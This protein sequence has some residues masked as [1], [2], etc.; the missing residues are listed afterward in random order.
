[1]QNPACCEA[2]GPRCTE[3]AEE[4]SGPR[5]AELT[6]RRRGRRPCCR[7]MALGGATGG[8][9]QRGGRLYQLPRWRKRM[10]RRT[11]GRWLAPGAARHPNA[12]QWQVGQAGGGPAACAAAAA[13]VTLNAPLPCSLSPWAKPHPAPRLSRARSRQPTRARE[14]RRA[15]LL[16]W[17]LIQ[18]KSDS[19]TDL[20]RLPKKTHDRGA[21]RGCL[22]GARRLPGSSLDFG[23]ERSA[24]YRTGC[25]G[26]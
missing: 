13:A 23:L 24:Q 6:R 25:L 1:M 17:G 2:A 19:S 20:C 16:L 12:D 4:G 26:R 21:A 14:P 15:C 9:G 11:P 22:P 18:I 3:R 8:E 7:C 10:H 5:G